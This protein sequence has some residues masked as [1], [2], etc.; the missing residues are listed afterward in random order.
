MNRS[1]IAVSTTILASLLGAN[2]VR[3]DYVELVNGDLIHGEVVSLDD[4]ELRLMSNIHGAVII[5]RD[6]VAGIGFGDRRPPRPADDA[7]RVGTRTRAAGGRIVA[8]DGANVTAT[9]PVAPLP[10]QDIVRQLRAQGLSAENVAELQKAIPM[11]K[12]PGAKRYFDDTVKGLVEG[13]LNVE[14]IRKQA[15]RARDEYQKSIKGLGPDAERALNQAFG[16][17]MQILERF[18]R[19]SDPKAA[20]QKQ[21][22]P[23]N[24]TKQPGPQNAPQQ[25]VD[26]TP[27]PAE[28]ER[29]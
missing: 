10:A 6:K 24:G 2:F 1:I 8:G 9:V 4:Q 26:T 20:N 7:A 21:P 28:K 16:G 14:D 18:I 22:A 15:I 23:A 11:L 27:Q 13:D 5:A 12:D 3:A 17:Y 19:E 25:P 29:R